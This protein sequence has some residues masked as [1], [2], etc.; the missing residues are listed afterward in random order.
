MSILIALLLS[1]NT[2]ANDKVLHL[3]TSAALTYTLHEIGL[4]P[5]ES[6]IIVNVAGACKELSDTS[7]DTGDILANVAGSTFAVI[8]IEL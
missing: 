8:V 6:W 2:E 1:L 7:V 5:I 3:S 4:S